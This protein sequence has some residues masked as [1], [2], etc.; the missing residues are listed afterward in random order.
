M[1]PDR[2]T[3]DPTGELSGQIST[4][5]VQL[6]KEHSGKGPSRCRTYLEEDMVVVLLRG[7][8]TLA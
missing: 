4:R 7:G 3:I 8:F 1:V 5:F 2:E 6:L